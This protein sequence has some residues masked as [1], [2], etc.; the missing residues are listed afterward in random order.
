M[1]P[2][3]FSYGDLNEFNDSYNDQVAY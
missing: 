2:I 1:T 3:S